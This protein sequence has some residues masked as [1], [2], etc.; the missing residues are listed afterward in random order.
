MHFERLLPYGN[1]LPQKCCIRNKPKL[2]S[3]NNHVSLLHGHRPGLGWASGE[4]G[5]GLLQETL[6][7][8][9]SVGFLDMF[10]L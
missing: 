3:M 8:L 2:V 4:A 9:G 5:P 1:P 7:V 10:F 6:L